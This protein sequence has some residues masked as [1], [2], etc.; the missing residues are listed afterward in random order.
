[1]RITPEDGRAEVAW[2][3]LD[4]FKRPSWMTWECILRMVCDLFIAVASVG[5]CKLPYSYLSNIPSMSAEPSLDA[6]SLNK[7][8]I[9]MHILTTALP[10]PSSLGH[11]QHCV[12]LS[13]YSKFFRRHWLSSGFKLYWTL[14]FLLNFF[15]SSFSFSLDPRLK[16][17][18][19]AKQGPERAWLAEYKGQ[20]NPI[21]TFAWVF[22]DVIKAHL[23]QSP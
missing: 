8:L 2:S 16:V 3:W 11:I 12:V 5:T 9:G 13:L 22:F 14:A 1:M 20:K 23:L 7:F 21:E 15:F 17:L 4:S 10:N 19:C 18:Y 6:N